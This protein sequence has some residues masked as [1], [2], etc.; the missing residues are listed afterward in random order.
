MRKKLK[1]EPDEQVIEAVLY[2]NPSK[3]RRWLAKYGGLVC[4]SNDDVAQRY[5][6]LRNEARARTERKWLSEMGDCLPETTFRV[7]W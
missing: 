7:V 4:M 1:G 6:S 3:P 5:R 2:W